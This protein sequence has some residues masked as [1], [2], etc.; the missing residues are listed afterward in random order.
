MFGFS[1]GQFKKT[2]FRF[3][4]LRFKVYFLFIAVKISVLV[5]IYNM[6]CSICQTLTVSKS[7]Y[8]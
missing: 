8:I 2:T 5:F 6:I 7:L 4:A 1:Q 3:D